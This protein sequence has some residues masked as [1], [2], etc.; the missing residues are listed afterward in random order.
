MS[1]LHHVATVD[2]AQEEQDLLKFSWLRFGID[3]HK[4]NEWNLLMEQPA[5]LEYIHNYTYQI[6]G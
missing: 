3:E 6:S 1:N 5:N 4:I 2:L